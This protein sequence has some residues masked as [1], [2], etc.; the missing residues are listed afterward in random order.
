[1]ENILNKALKEVLTPRYSEELRDASD[2]GYRFSDEFERKM[3]ELIRKTDRPFY[4]YMPVFAAA[5]CAVIAI[6]CAVL[7]PLL[8]NNDIA[9][10]PDDGGQ[11]SATS[12]SDIG[13]EPTSMTP[14]I[15]HTSPTS[16]DAPVNSDTSEPIVD[17]T[18]DTTAPIVTDDTT[19]TTTSAS[20]GDDTS[21]HS[22][23]LV[24]DDED[25]GDDDDITIEED[26]VTVDDDD[27]IAVTPDVDVEETIMVDVNDGETLGEA[28]NKMIDGFSFENMWAY[29]AEYA[30]DGSGPS[31]RSDGLNFFQYEYGFVQ[32]LVHGL[33]DAVKSPDGF[34]TDGCASL[35]VWI[36]GSR[37]K[38][39]NVRISNASAW[40]NY[41]EY[42]NMEDAEYTVDDDEDDYD[43]PI[44]EDSEDNYVFDIYENGY[45]VAKVNH[46][47]KSDDGRMYLYQLGSNFFKIDTAKCKALFDKLKARYIPS[48][49]RTVGDVSDALGLNAG[50]IETAW[51]NVE[52]IYDTLIYRGKIGYDF[53]E[54]LFSLHASDKI[55]NVKNG[56]EE[57]DINGEIEIELYTKDSAHLKIYLS[58]DGMCFVSEK[59]NGYWF[60]IDQSD[61]EN[62]M[63]SISAANGFSIPIFHTLAEYPGS[64]YFKQIDQI[65]V[66]GTKDGKKG[67]YSLKDEAELK[68]IYDLIKSEMKTAK[69][70]VSLHKYSLVKPIGINIYV[71]NF[72]NPISM[73]ADEILCFRIMRYIPFRMSDGFTEKIRKLVESSPAATFEEQYYVDD[74]DDDD[75]PAVNDVDED[76]VEDD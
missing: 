28:M 35:T 6:G 8:N 39:G 71:K 14:E 30:P 34:S 50:N 45:V 12:E 63:N 66:E 9:V 22:E 62:A 4:R 36:R 55:Q 11:T 33:G 46:Y 56:E 42:Y 26:D 59:Y 38:V 13:T 47:V 19:G 72:L 24:D 57:Y 16:D 64:N 18:S 58:T 3:R 74:D 53:I 31:V 65:R 5:A 60:R 73:G 2:T 70:E 52:Y 67:V 75:E 51:V 68:K 21:G 10:V 20:G 29:S 69:Y 48:D 54:K 23:I 76:Y 15:S 37:P 27:D 41:G 32:D 7:I 61:I 25:D 43:E 49:V 40:L 17:V 44:T 1:M